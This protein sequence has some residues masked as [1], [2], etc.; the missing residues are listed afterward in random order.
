M[1]RQSCKMLVL[2][3]KLRWSVLKAVLTAML[4]ILACL[5]PQWRLSFLEC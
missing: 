2:G 4:P 5:L 1:S 3:K